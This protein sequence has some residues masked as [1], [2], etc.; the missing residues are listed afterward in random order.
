M[1]EEDRDIDLEEKPQLPLEVPSG[2]TAG[3]SAKNDLIDEN[4]MAKAKPYAFVEKSPGVKMKKTA[5]QP[6]GSG[7]KMK[8]PGS[9]DGDQRINKPPRSKG[10]VKEEYDRELAEIAVPKV[11]YEPAPDAAQK[12]ETV[13]KRW[14]S[15][16]WNYNY[17]Q[18]KMLLEQTRCSR[19]VT[20]ADWITR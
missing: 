12:I 13:G 19:S 11:K 8:A 14:D 5:K 9:E 2:T 15:V 1:K 4:P 10:V 17:S 3:R 16:E 18:L 20:K 6:A 7:T